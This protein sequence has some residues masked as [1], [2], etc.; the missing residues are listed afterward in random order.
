MIEL[1]QTPVFAAWLRSVK[2]SVT[3]ARIAA[4]V[5]RLAF[6]NPG[7]A[8]PVGGGVSE[9][10]LHFGPGYRVYFVPRGAMLIILLCGGDKA[11][12]DRDITLALHMTQA[13]DEED[14]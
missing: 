2:D 8:R 4:R 12:Q 9:L 3:R 5:Q 7:D 14:A 13:L 10:R 1:R 11:T 6:G